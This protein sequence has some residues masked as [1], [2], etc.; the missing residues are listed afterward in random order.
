MLGCL[1]LEGQTLL[2]S[3]MPARLAEEDERFHE[4]K[5]QRVFVCDTP[6]CKQVVRFSSKLN[7]TGC[8]RAECEFAGSFSDHGWHDLPAALRKE[9]WEE[10]F[11]NA[12]WHCHHICL[13][14]VTLNEE[15]NKKR[16]DR[17][18]L[19]QEFLQEQA[20]ACKRRRLVY[21]SAASSA[22]PACGKGGKA[23]N[24][25]R[26]PA[27]SFAARSAYPASNK[28]AEAASLKRSRADMEGGQSK[29]TKKG[30]STTP[31][32]TSWTWTR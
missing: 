24:K 18:R 14:E 23:G 32:P 19:Y 22:C 9:A 3:R 28:G 27:S 4:Q 17:I 5:K 8:K 11:I 2:P 7:K 21:C 25:G 16:N 20:E 31:R 10:R 1:L 15:Q 26:A 12:T 6:G 13:A 30:G 29:G